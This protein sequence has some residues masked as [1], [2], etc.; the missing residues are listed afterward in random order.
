M[1]NRLLLFLIGCI[2]TRVLFVIYAKNHPEHNQIMG[3]LALIPAIGFMY[4]YMNGLRKTG[5]EVFGDK[6]WWDDLRTVHALLYGL[7]AISAFN[8]SSYAWIFLLIDVIIGFSSWATYHYT[9]NTFSN[10][11]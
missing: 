5:A 6:I 11:Y 2:G 3:A 9:H 4:I 8:N 10:L 7:F 1:I